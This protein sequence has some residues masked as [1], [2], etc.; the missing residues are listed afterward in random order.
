[1][2]LSNC[3][4]F[5]KSNDQ[6]TVLQFTKNCKKNKKKNPK[7]TNKKHWQFWFLSSLSCKECNFLQLSTPF[8]SI[9]QLQS[10]FEKKKLAES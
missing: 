7:Q 8:I 2:N 4:E 6:G 1:M 3:E 9:T 5:F 10:K